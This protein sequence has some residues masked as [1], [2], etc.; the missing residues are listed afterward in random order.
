M[1]HTEDLFF[2]FGGGNPGGEPVA[3]PEALVEK[4]RTSSSGRTP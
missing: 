3:S 2:A 1:W 4:A